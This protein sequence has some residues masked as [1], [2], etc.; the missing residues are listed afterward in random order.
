MSQKIIQTQQQ[1]QAQVQTQIMTPQQMMLVKLLELPVDALQ[2]RVE[3]ECLENPWL[4]RADNGSDNGEGTT[5]DDGYNGEQNGESASS[6]SSDDEAYDYRTEDD[7]PDYLLQTRNSEGKGENIEYGDTLSF[8]DKMKEQISEF[9]L[10]D[11]EQEV[12]EY[13]IGSLEDD[14][15]LKKDLQQI[16]DEAE[17]YQNI[18]TSKDELERLLHVLW[19]FDPPGIG[20][21][22]LQECLLI[23]IKRDTRNP[24][25]QQLL[26]IME[27]FYD[28][29]IHKRWVRI[30]ERMQL[31]DLQVEEIQRE[32]LRLNPKPGSAMG[33]ST[34]GNTQQVT[35]DFIVETDLYGNLTMNLNQ[36]N[37]PELIISPDATEKLAAYEKTG[38]TKLTRMMQEDMHFTRQYVDRGQM[39]INAL[40]QRRDS[41]VRTMHAIIQLQKPFFLEGDE[42]LLR[43]MVLEDVS[44]LTG[45]DISTVSRICNSKYVQTTYGTFRLK[46]F[47]SHKAIQTD[48]NDTV[49]SRQVMAALK[50]IIDGE[51]K[52]KPLSDRELT[53]L[54]EKRGYN[55]ARRTIAKY[56]ELLGIPVARMRR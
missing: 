12:M 10:T 56:R 44:A 39:F 2:Q 9:D 35:P 45:Y 29:F 5:S 3:N 4:E 8:Y 6:S 1:T 32:I 33:E 26:R 34:S 42:A 41:M 48:D 15:L 22:S 47:F 19:Q 7:I 20:A 43:P 16:A 49:S 11:H 40:K 53:D 52:S 13:L 54:M 18:I 37:V 31:T 25:Q 23:Q 28:D 17:I 27:K 50:E 55:I 14:G 21:R 30:Q 51:N 46:W 38:E 24:Y 36:G